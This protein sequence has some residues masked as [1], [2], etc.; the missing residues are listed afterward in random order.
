MMGRRTWTRPRR[1]VHSDPAEDDV[2]LDADTAAPSPVRNTLKW[3]AIL[4]GSA[5]AAAF[6]IHFPYGIRWVGIF[7]GLGV[8]GTAAGLAGTFWNRAG[9]ATVAGFA[10]LF[11]PLVASPLLHEVYLKQVGDRYDAL[12]VDTGTERSIKGDAIPVCR[13]VDTRGKVHDLGATENCDGDYRPGKHVVL[14]EDPVG[15][16][17]PWLGDPADLSTGT[18]LIALAGGL[19]AASAGSVA[20]AGLRRR[21]DA[22]MAAR[23]ARRYPRGPQ[24]TART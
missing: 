16:L 4:V 6:L 15:I 8:A 22:Q 24:S 13:I 11:L 7:F 9:A 18:A 1:R 10:F 14:Y 19:Y 20:Y 21:T 23:R 17:D 12:V 3:L 5:T 2:A